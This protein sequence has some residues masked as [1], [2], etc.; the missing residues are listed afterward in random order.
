MAVA[1]PQQANGSDPAPRAVPKNI[2][3]LSDGTGNSAAAIWRTNVWRVYRS[4][5]LADPNQL[6]IYDDGVG[7]SSFKLFALLG[8]AVGW[9]LKRNVIH[10]YAFLCRHYKGN[11]RIYCFGFSRG[12]FTVRILADLVANEG[13][14][15]SAGLSDRELKRQA[16][17]VFQ[18]RRMKGSVRSW[19]VLRVHVLILRILRYVLVTIL[20]KLSGRT[21][22]YEVKIGHKPRI[23][24]LGVWDT[25]GAYGLPV[26]EMTRGVDLFF[27]PLS[28]ADQRASEKIDRLCHALALDDER[29]TFHPLLW[30]E[31][32]EKTVFPRDGITRVDQERI[33]QVWFAGMHSNVGGG[34]PDDGMAHVPLDWMLGEAEKCGL[35]LKRLAVTSL[36][37][38]DD[39]AT[40]YNTTA[41]HHIQMTADPAGRIY[42]SRARLA[43][44]YRYGPRHLDQLKNDWLHG[45]NVDLPKIHESV[46][47]RIKVGAANYAPFVLPQDYAVVTRS[48]SIQRDESV[49]SLY[50]VREQE[51]IWN[52]V[53]YRRVTYFATLGATLFLAS[54]ALLDDNVKG[55]LSTLDAHLRENVWGVMLWPLDK[56]KMGFSCLSQFGSSLLEIISS[57][58]TFLP[59]VV[60]GVGAKVSNVF[61]SAA[62]KLVSPFVEIAK[63]TLPR[64]LGDRLDV[65]KT[66]PVWTATWL[67]ITA[68]LVLRGS[69]IE[70]KIDMRMREI[71]ENINSKKGLTTTEPGGLL[72]RMRTSCPYRHTLLAMKYYIIPAMFAYVILLLAL[73]AIFAGWQLL[74]S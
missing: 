39:V 24:F 61:S 66:Q 11:D 38:G 7:T 3:V 50:R 59:D 49:T 13:L 23:R 54:A 12:A 68:L 64:F 41:R 73:A 16:K 2:V 69:R 21:A 56:G 46:F 35:R 74:W 25:V 26:E 8:G 15:D 62:E 34:Y 27:W 30:D 20:S 22:P 55:Y 51:R 37:S 72:Y 43:S 71:W 53:W 48:G 47:E 32:Q 29:T 65:Y 19:H 44:Y 67:L 40:G 52:L 58:T 57:K 5:D 28:M 42:D 60:R 10:L 6:A 9:G 63:G 70:N 17:F 4:L 33:S 36:Y 14:I 31:R 1:G 18:A 45:V